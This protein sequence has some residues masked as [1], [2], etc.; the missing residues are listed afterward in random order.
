[1]PLIRSAI[2]IK[3]LIK[4]TKTDFGCSLSTR[5]L[6]DSHYNRKKKN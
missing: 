5:I 4:Y 6:S 2:S 1:M 3:S